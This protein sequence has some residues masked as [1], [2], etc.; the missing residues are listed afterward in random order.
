MNPILQRMNGQK[1]QNNISS[2]KDI[3]SGDPNKVMQN[4]MSNNPQ[5]ADFV[6][7]NKGKSPQQIAMEYGVDFNQ[8]KN[9]LR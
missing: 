1:N 8:I 7:K 2:I 5:F 6:N 4:M 3:L 9:L